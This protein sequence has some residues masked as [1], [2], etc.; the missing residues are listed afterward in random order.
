MLTHT[1]RYAHTETHQRSL[2]S[3]VHRRAQCSK[4]KDKLSA[5][6]AGICPRC[7]RLDASLCLSTYVP[8]S[9]HISFTHWHKHTNTQALNYWWTLW[10]RDD[11]FVT[12]IQSHSL[13]ACPSLCPLEFTFCHLTF[14]ERLMTA[15]SADISLLPT[16]NPDAVDSWHRRHQR[17]CNGAEP[18]FQISARPRHPWETCLC[19]RIIKLFHVTFAQFKS[20]ISFNIS[21]VNKLFI[22]TQF[23]WNNIRFK[24]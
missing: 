15:L 13:K 21:P 24:V 2:I 23:Q 6:T 19:P 11:A 1:H 3:T 22:H 5:I 12:S 9:W 20:C 17:A 8:F 10:H 7:R 16:L 14:T 18:K 4:S